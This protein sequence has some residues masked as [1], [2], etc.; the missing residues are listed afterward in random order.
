MV[1]ADPNVFHQLFLSVGPLSLDSLEGRLLVF[2]AII[3]G[4]IVAALVYAHFRKSKTNAKIPMS[5]ALIFGLTLLLPL[6]AEYTI[7]RPY[8]G[9][10]IVFS[11]VGSLILL[12][13]LGFFLK[14]F[15]GMGLFVHGARSL[16]LRLFFMVYFYVILTVLVYSSF[17]FFLGDLINPTNIVL[18]PEVYRFAL[19]TGVFLVL[20]L[21]RM[22]LYF[23]SAGYDII[24]EVARDVLFFSFTLY[25]LKWMIL[26]AGATLPDQLSSIPSEQVFYMGLG[27]SVLG[28]AGEGLILYLLT[29]LRMHHTVLNF[30]QI[31]R[32]FVQQLL[33][34]DRK[35]KSIDDFVPP[36]LETLSEPTRLGQ[37]AM[38]LDRKVTVKVK[39]HSIKGSTLV[40]SSLL[41]V[42]II[43]GIL[44][45]GGSR[46]F[47]AKI[48]G[49]K[50]SLAMM[51][52]GSLTGSYTIV[53]SEQ[54]DTVDVATAYAIPIVQILA[55]NQSF[56]AP[57]ANRYLGLNSSNY[58]VK[59]TGKSLFVT[60]SQ[61]PI[62]VTLKYSALSPPNLDQTGNDQFAYRGFFRD[63]EFYYSLWRHGFSNITKICQASTTGTLDTH[64]EVIYASTNQTQTV[65]LDSKITNGITTLTDDTT[66]VTTVTS[67]SEDLKF[68][69]AQSRVSTSFVELDQQP[70]FDFSETR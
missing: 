54:M 63:A 20:F 23:K 9:F 5:L 45:I 10:S 39:G 27:F 1:L 55:G 41:L 42:L 70:R 44:F 6:V 69:L 40:L 15:S 32:S 21:Y 50:I 68:L 33:P 19:P 31:I 67:F 17:V 60:I 47:T 8:L 65:R 66:S 35:Q 26:A 34:R 14:Y 37:V 18:T 48:S 57:L 3:V 52:S 61:I 64:L 38:R 58:L 22:R 25:F 62:F 7:Q 2:S 12:M 16:A 59:Y 29:N 28:I 49:Y 4:L 43:F 24:G 51:D 13:L 56:Q 46:N 53:S 11:I 36:P 30:D